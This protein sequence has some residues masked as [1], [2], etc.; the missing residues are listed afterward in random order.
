LTGEGFSWVEIIHGIGFNYKGT[1]HGRKERGRRNYSY[2][3][4]SMQEVAQKLT[5]GHRSGLRKPIRVIQNMIDLMMVDEP[6][7]LA[8]STVRIHDDYT[9]THSINVALLSMYLGKQIGL[10][11]SSLERL[12]ICGILHDIGKIEIPKRILNKPGKLTNKE[13]EEVK[14]HSINSVRMIVKIDASQHRKSGLLLPPFEHHIKYDL[15]GYP[16][17]RRKKPLSL[18]GNI[19]SIADVYD[20]LTSQRVYRLNTLSPDFA[21]AMMAKNAKK[22]FDPILLKVFINMLGIYPIGTILQLNKGRLGIVTKTPKGKGARP[23]VMLLTRD[24]EGAF[25][26]GKEVDLSE[27]N[28]FTNDYQINILKSLHPSECGIQPA[29]FL[30]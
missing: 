10:S 27:R 9:Y 16:Q 20:A 14:K 29:Q 4:S 21:L 5:S 1:A 6:L 23:H 30:L 11:R 24:S 25:K 15:S 8:L 7:F 3:L 26:K 22:A 28:P 13:F 19:I 18:F 12:G 17:S 2:L